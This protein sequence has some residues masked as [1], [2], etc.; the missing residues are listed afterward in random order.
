MCIFGKQL[1]HNVY[2]NVLIIQ[3]KKWVYVFMLGLAMDF[4]ACLMGFKINVNALDFA[5]V[6]A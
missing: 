1:A 6:L 5:M 3:W 2:T 4:N